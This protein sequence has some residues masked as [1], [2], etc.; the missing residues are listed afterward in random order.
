DYPLTTGSYAAVMTK[1]KYDS[2]PEE[3]QKVIDELASEMAEFQGV[4]MDRHAKESVEWA[5]EKGAEVIEFSPEEAAKL[6]E[7]IQKSNE[8]YIEKIE[9]EGYPAHEFSERITELISEYSN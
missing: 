3:V 9:S 4:T 6:D 1:E 8:A 7:I 5:I 2:L